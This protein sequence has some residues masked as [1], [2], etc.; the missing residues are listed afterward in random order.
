MPRTSVILPF[1]LRN[2]IPGCIVQAFLPR[3]DQR[4]A[5]L[6]EEAI[7]CVTYRVMAC[8]T[9]H[10]GRHDIRTAIV[11]PGAVN[12]EHEGFHLQPPHW[13]GRL[14]HDLIMEAPNAL[15]SS[16]IVQAAQ[17]FFDLVGPHRDP[18]LKLYTPLEASADVVGS[19]IITSWGQEISDWFLRHL[20]SIIAS[21]D[22]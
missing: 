7:H 10:V 12:L 9:L 4:E 15:V 14:S 5:A 19:W 13:T 16:A 21:L 20:S 2:A 3:P 22:G 11:P 18:A 17:D 8:G 1:S 6:C